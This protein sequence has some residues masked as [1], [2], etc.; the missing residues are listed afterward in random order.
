M[1]AELRTLA[2]AARDAKDKMAKYLLVAAEKGLE[3]F[4]RVSQLIQVVSTR[5]DALRFAVEVRR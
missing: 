4:S 2:G 3:D 1:L 5:L